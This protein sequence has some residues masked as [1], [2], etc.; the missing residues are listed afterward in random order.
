MYTTT[1][2]FETE[3]GIFHTLIIQVDSEPEFSKELVDIVEDAFFQTIELL[4][5]NVLENFKEFKRAMFPDK[6]ILDMAI[7]YVSNGKYKDVIKSYSIMTSAF[8]IRTITVCLENKVFHNMTP[9]EISSAT[10]HAL[11]EPLWWETLGKKFFYITD[12]LNKFELIRQYL[13]QHE[14]LK[15]YY[16]YEVFFFN[17][18]IKEPEVTDHMIEEGD[19]FLYTW[20]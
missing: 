6:K 8:G 13:K 15:C 14:I 5:N 17:I 11:R 7:F 20:I 10:E 3:I 16:N 9:Q 18:G 12:H 4:K 19:W 2:T 1:R